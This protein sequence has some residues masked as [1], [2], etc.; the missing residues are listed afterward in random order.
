M[1]GLRTFVVRYLLSQ[2]ECGFAI[3]QFQCEVVVTFL[4]SLFITTLAL[5]VG[6]APVT[7]SAAEIAVSEA[8][9]QKLDST[10]RLERGIALL[11]Q[12]PADV[13]AG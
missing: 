6:P 10:A 13:P 3:R 9:L 12:Y 8:M 5:A 1:S 7:R 2:S 4:I 11:E